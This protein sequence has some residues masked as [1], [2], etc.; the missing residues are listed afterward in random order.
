[1]PGLTYIADLVKSKTFKNLIIL[2]VVASVVYYAIW[3]TYYRLPSRAKFTDI[4]LNPVALPT[5]YTPSLEKALTDY[6][7][8]FNPATITKLAEARTLANSTLTGNF[9]VVNS[10]INSMNTEIDNKL[11]ELNY[12]L[13]K[14]IQKNY[15]NAHLLNNEREH[16]K[17]MLDDLPIRNI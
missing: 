17:T 7:C 3:V 2:L 10:R 4:I 6:N 16:Q 15:Y 12:N 14:Q 11:Q 1:M 5:T 8:Y 13:L 9:N